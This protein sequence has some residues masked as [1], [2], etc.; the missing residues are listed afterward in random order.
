ME[1]CLKIN[2][3]LLS[4][5]KKQANIISSILSFEYLLK[6]APIITKNTAGMTKEMISFLS[7]PFLKIAILDILLETWNKAV[8]PSTEWKSRKKPAIGT[9]KSD[10]PKPPTVPSISASRAK[11]MKRPR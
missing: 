11:A 10:E 5:I 3:R 1:I 8:T 2:N 6:N 4:I 7:T 9:K